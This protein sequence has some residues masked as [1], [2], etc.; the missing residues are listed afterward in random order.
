MLAFFMPVLLI[1]LAG[2]AVSNITE[3]LKHVERQMHHKGGHP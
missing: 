2:P 1:A 3:T